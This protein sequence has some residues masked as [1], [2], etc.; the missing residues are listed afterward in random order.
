[1]RRAI[2]ISRGEET[3][4]DHRARGGTAIVEQPWS[5]VRTLSVDRGKRLK[6][7]PT[8]SDGFVANARF[9]R[10]TPRVEQRTPQVWRRMEIEP[11]AVFQ[12][13]AWSANAELS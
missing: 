4:A 7:D 12:L 3:A 2:S 10:V 1:M 11:S 8:S 13:C 9:F 5:E 6:F